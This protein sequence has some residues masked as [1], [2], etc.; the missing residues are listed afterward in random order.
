MSI[1][2]KK[3]KFYAIFFLFSVCFLTLK[4]QNTNDFSFWNWYQLQYFFNKH[5]Y[6]NFQY[7]Y[8]L[9]QNASQFDKSNFYFIYGKNFNKHINLELLYQF[10]TSR[11]RDNHTFYIGGIYRFKLKKIQLNY[12]LSIQHIRYYLTGNEELDNSFSELRNRIRLTYPLNKKI[13]VSLSTEPYLKFSNFEN[14]RISRLRNV[15]SVS[16]ELN[17]YQSVSLFYLFEPEFVRTGLP[18]NDYVLGLT[19]QINLPKKLKKIGKIFK[20]DKSS[21][22][23]G[24]ETL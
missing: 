22:N 14:L 7:Q 8:R 23:S 3:S 6:V 16:Y 17:N 9:N 5:D 21:K 12:R 10:T 11:R 19:Y 20:G 4:C 13:D 15:A 24:S 1:T 2:F 18:N